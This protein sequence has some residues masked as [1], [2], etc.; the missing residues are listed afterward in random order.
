MLDEVKRVVFFIWGAVYASAISYLDAAANIDPEPFFT[1][2][3]ILVII[4]SSVWV[5]VLVIGWFIENW[6][7]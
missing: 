6:D 2:P 5:I 4:F 3:S 7:N 1:I